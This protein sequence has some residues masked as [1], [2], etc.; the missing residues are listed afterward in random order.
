MPGHEKPI[1]APVATRFETGWRTRLDVRLYFVTDPVF[2]DAAR[3]AAA[4]VA[5]GVTCVQVR[6]KDDPHRLRATSLAVRQALPSRVPV[7]ANDDL[8]VARLVDGIH[9]GVDDVSPAQARRVLGERA[10]VGWSINTV[11][12]LDDLT[13]L[14]ACDYVAASPVWPTPTKPD[15]SPPFGLEGVRALADRLRGL[16]HA[17]PLVGIGGICAGSAGSVVAAGASGVAVVSAVGA[18]ADPAAAARGLRA[19]VDRALARRETR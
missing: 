7:L 3:V 19:E 6:D 13:A 12:Q 2:P 1:E 16:R 8:E 11:E 10:I 4:G 18:A 15:S 14:Q 5:G 17:V 9:V